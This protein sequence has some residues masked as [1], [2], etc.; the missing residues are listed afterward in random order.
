ML[1]DRGSAARIVHCRS[2]GTAHWPGEPSGLSC[3]DKRSVCC[4]PSMP[5]IR[6]ATGVGPG[7]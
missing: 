2:C 7:R 5:F 3:E 6:D 4:A 1:V